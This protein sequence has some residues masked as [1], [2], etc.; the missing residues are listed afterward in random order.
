VGAPH[1]AGLVSGPVPGLVTGLTPA[2]VRRHTADLSPAELA[3]ARTL[4][5][6]AFDHFTDSDWDHGLGG[7]HALVVADGRVL[8]HGSLV[9][10]RLLQGDRSLRCGF[11]EA[12]AVHPS[13]RRQGLGHAVMAA[14][15]E[16]APA[17]DLLA[18]SSSS[19]GVPLYRARGWQR[20]RGPAYVLAPDG[21]RR[22]PGEEEALHVLPGG[23]PL[24]LDGPI[25]CDWRDG[26]V[27]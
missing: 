25:A 14:L 12:V 24:D 15:E 19:S 23:A 9:Q 2:V 8:A 4:M 13:R 5:D 20:W 21:L 3:G 27:W 1:G 10:R 6:E 17:Y 18:L 26:E 22:T 16:L 7:M 11:V